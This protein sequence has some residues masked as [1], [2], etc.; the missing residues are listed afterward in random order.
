MKNKFY[1]TTSIAYANAAPHIGFAMEIC[2]ADVLARYH[3]MLSDDVFFLSGTDE[4]GAKMKK[5][6]EEKGIELQKFAD[7][8]SAKFQLLLD[9]LDISNND[10]IRTTDKKRHWPAAQK[11]WNKL[12]ESGDIYKESYEGYYCVGCEAYLTEKDLINGKC[13][14]HQK[15]PEK[16]KEEN[17]FFKL[18]KYSKIIQEKIESGELEIL[19]EARKNEILNV[20][21]SGLRDISFSRPKNVLDWGVPVPNDDSQTMYV[22]CDA[23]TNYIS[24]LGYGDFNNDSPLE[25]GKSAK[26]MGCVKFQKYWP[27]DIHV[28]GKDILRFHTAIWPAMLLS[29]GLPFPKK[30]FVHGFITSGGQKMSKS[31]GNVIDPF[32]VIDKYGVDALRYYLLKEIPSMSDGD[33]SYERFKEVYQADLANGIGNLTARI[34]AL[35]TKNQGSR[36]KNQD[37]N[38]E[39]KTNAEDTWLNYEKLLNNFKLN[40]A[41]EITRKLMSACDEYIEK[42]KPWQL[43]GEK[44]E[45][46]VYDLLESLRHITWMI[47]PFMPE[48]SMKIFT[49]LFADE[50]ERKN[51]LNKTL[52]QAQKWGGLK[53]GTKI[54]KGEILFPRLAS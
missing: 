47:Y 35:A 36:I 6:A 16:I 23:L 18:S 48:T 26:Q 46:V 30:I 5:T 15:A 13:P 17:Y 33:F 29:A 41:L 45:K 54:K 3:R 52:E 21:K 9:T 27:A 24:A 14:N 43:E 50:N 37:K 19:P 8:N 2:Q 10:F 20:I 28:I 31:I 22:W 1:I 7:E 32:E 42:N 40:E 39:F 12:V 51:E 49:Q 34:I 25:R 4:N 44:K 53:S 38:L 11:L